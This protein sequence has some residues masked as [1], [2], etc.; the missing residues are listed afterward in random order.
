MP[1]SLSLQRQLCQ[2]LN[3]L[4]RVPFAGHSQ[5]RSILCSHGS[6]ANF[7]L[8]FEE[9]PAIIAT[10]QTEYRAFMEVSCTQPPIW[11]TYVPGTAGQPR[12][13]TS[14]QRG[15]RAVHATGQ[16]KTQKAGSTCSSR[17]VRVCTP[18]QSWGAFFGA[19]NSKRHDCCWRSAHN[20][21]ERCPAQ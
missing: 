5:D 8:C 12:A 19:S 17:L 14:Y 1:I 20:A 18:R 6:N 9:L 21:R 4:T 16:C 2:I 15:Q 3:V 7:K 11:I 10:A 13:S